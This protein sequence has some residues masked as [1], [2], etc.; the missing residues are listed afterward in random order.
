MTFFQSWLALVRLACVIAL[1]F[2]L[3]AQL[4][5]GGKISRTLARWLSRDLASLETKLRALILG[6][7]AALPE[8]KAR[9]RKRARRAQ[10]DHG[11]GGFASE[12]SR[13][14]QV[15]FHLAPPRG[16]ARLR[17]A[18]GYGSLY[19]SPW[20]LAERFEAALRVLENPAPFIRRAAARR[21]TRSPGDAP[22]TAGARPGVQGIVGCNLEPS[23][24]DGASGERT[25]KPPP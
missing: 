11:R 14:W 19:V 25:C 22:A 17:R 10:R 5:R 1:R 16:S 20:P 7:A 9:I 21:S 18:H 23:P 15:A 6:A 2:G 4:A 12:V 8:T 3:P 13:D 24:P